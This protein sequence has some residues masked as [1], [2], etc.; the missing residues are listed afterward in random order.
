MASSVA[1]DGFE[2]GIGRLGRIFA[3]G[4]YGRSRWIS[5]RNR[6]LPGFTTNYKKLVKRRAMLAVLLQGNAKWARAAV[7]V[8]N[9]I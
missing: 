1:R 7:E 3:S 5:S 9:A 6:N 4:R 2:N 8:R